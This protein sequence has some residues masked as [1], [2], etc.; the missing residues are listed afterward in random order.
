MGGRSYEGDDLGAYFVYPHPDYPDALIGV[1][2]AT[3]VPGMRATMPNNYISGITGFP[4]LMIFRAD[5]MKDG[6]KAVETAG[7]FDNDWSLN[8]K[9]LVTY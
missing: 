9:D 7:F 6:L 8:S 4:D 3:G 5:M 1:V 2:T